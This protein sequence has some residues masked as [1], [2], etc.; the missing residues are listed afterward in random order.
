MG[1]SEKLRLHL[2][3]QVV[4][5]AH[6]AL[7]IGKKLRLHDAKAGGICSDADYDNSKVFGRSRS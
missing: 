3:K 1:I 5:S 7:G 2:L 6:Q 4:S